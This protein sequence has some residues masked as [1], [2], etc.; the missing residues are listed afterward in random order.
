MD[1]GLTL[2]ILQGI[3]LPLVV[4]MMSVIFLLLSPFKTRIYSCMWIGD[5][6]MGTSKSRDFDRSGDFGLCEKQERFL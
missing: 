1:L 2:M 4:L 6:L 3:S 5:A